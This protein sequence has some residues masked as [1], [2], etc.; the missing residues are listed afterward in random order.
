MWMVD[1]RRRRAAGE[2]IRGW[3]DG[4]R[5]LRR[6]SRWV[7]WPLAVV[8]VFLLVPIWGV[9]EKLTQGTQML[10]DPRNS[11]EQ[12]G[13]DLVGF[14]D[15]RMF[16]AVHA[17]PVWPAAVAAI[18]AVALWELRRLPRELFAALVSIVAVA[19]LIAG[20]MRL[21]EYGWYFHFKVLAFVAPLVVVAAAVGLSRLRRWGT[22]LLVVW[23]AS[24]TADARDEVAGTFDQL[25]RTTV[26]L[27]DWA[28]ALPPDASIRLDMQ[29]GAQLW[30]AYMLHERRLCSQRPLSE[31][32]YPHVPLSRAADYV[33]V[34]RLQ[35]PFDAEGGPLRRNSEFTLYRLRPGLPGGD[36]CSQEMVQTVQKIEYAGK[37]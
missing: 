15:E 7:R 22:V 20:S 35:R 19:A 3:R 33:V 27:R 28:A 1:R 36:R 6:Q 11:L 25:P 30:A 37:R 31:T 16:F 23:I 8:G 34:R 14:F 21:R 32:S 4:W 29:P 26:E 5:A 10:V 9:V 18:V 17:T 2:E 24:A 13:G 12:W